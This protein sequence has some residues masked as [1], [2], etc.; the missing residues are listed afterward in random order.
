MK[1]P[2]WKVIASAGIALLTFSS[3]S[4]CV[5]ERDHGPYTWDHGD[6]VDRYGHRESHWCD[7]HHEEEHCR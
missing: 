5:V 6:R 3:L 2:S 1:R 7:A 4:G